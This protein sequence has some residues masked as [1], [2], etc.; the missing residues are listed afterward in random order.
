MSPSACVFLHRLSP[1]VPCAAGPVSVHVL[2]G[3]RQGQR[4]EPGLHPEASQR[5]G[6]SAHNDASRA[7]P[8]EP[9]LAYLQWCQTFGYLY[10]LVIQSF[11]Y[12]GVFTCVYLSYL[13]RDYLFRKHVFS[14]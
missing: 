13:L 6:L 8:G 1:L 12:M 3:E 7:A 14:M 11:V 5:I 2:P 4:T 9:V 10:H